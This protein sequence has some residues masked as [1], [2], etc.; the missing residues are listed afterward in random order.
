MLN[1][2]VDDLNM[3]QFLPPALN[4]DSR[5]NNDRM[6]CNLDMELYTCF[7]L[8]PSM[9]LDRYIYWFL[10]PTNYKNICSKLEQKI[11]VNIFEEKNLAYIVLKIGAYMPGVNII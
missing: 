1:R 10:K 3:K 5:T 9:H 2:A 6:R 7:Q 11:C 8:W 4:T